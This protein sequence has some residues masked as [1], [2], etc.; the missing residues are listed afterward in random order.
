MHADF[1]IEDTNARPRGDYLSF[2]IFDGTDRKEGRISFTALA[3]LAPGSRD[4]H[5][6]VFAANFG[7]IREAVDKKMGLF[8]DADVVILNSNDF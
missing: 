7:K 3:L 2:E 1:M 5:A 8:P 6:D 4:L